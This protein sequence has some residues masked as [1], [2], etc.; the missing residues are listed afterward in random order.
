MPIYYTPFNPYDHGSWEIPN[1]IRVPVDV[2]D[3]SGRAI[4]AELIQAAPKPEREPTK[5][6][7]YADVK[8]GSV[9]VPI[10]EPIYGL[11]IK[12]RS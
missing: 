1:E 6:F 5:D 12:G 11:A 2:R 4:E 3:E 7:T 10:D 8:V 9:V